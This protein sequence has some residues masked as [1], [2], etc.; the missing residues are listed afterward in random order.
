MNRLDELRLQTSPVLT[1]LAAG[2]K[3]AGVI[4]DSVLPIIRATSDSIKLP[5]FSADAL[6]TGDDLRALR[7]A[8]KQGKWGV[9]YVTVTLEEH[10]VDYPADW[11]EL[12]AGDVVGL[13]VLA[14]NA[15]SAKRAV[16]LGREKAVATLLTNPTSYATGNSETVGSGSGWN[17]KTS[18]KSNVDVVDVILAKAELLRQKVGVTPNVFWCGAQ[19]WNAISR[20]TY[21]L[22][23]LAFAPATIAARQVTKEAFAAAIGVSRVL[24][25]GAV[26]SSD[27]ATISDIWG[28]AAGLCYVEDNPNEVEAPTFGMLAMRVWQQGA[29]NT[30]GFTATWDDAGGLVRH[31][32]YVEFYKPFI[33]MPEAGYLWLDT[34]K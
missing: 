34:V 2:Y 21:V 23:R 9:T 22:D 11:R 30:Y 3:P 26:A 31:V 33:A 6:P 17:E 5:K 18:G 24:V 8:P 20:N 14:R 4:G 32:A 25:G 12:Q 16:V 15:R 28:D 7:A 13:D 19:T 10:A 29:E 27:G 1:A